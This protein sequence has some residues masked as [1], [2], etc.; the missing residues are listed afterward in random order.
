M[1]LTLK[2]L[3]TICGDRNFQSRKTALCFLLNNIA[4]RH[5]DL[6]AP[7]RL[8]QFLAQ[9]LHE[10]GRLRYVKEI[11]GPTAAQTR[12]EGRRDLG[13][14]L[15]GDGK[16]F[17]GRDIIQIT[18]R[19]NYR[20]LSEWMDRKFGPD[21]VDFEANPDLLESE[22]YLGYGALWYWSTRVPSKF[23]ETGNIEMITRRV[24]GGLN[25][26]NDRLALYDRA[27]L[28]LLG[29]GPEEIRRFQGVAGVGMDGISGPKTRGAMHAALRAIKPT[30]PSVVAPS[31]NPFAALASLLSQ[32][33][34]AL[35]GGKKNG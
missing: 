3:N 13:N 5:T 33:I 9:V 29:Y 1:K 25:G 14:I 7:H 10:S 30:K 21:A 23:V 24:N 20:A 2:Q 28:V 35:F 17:L 15:P 22:E 32:I 6:A 16:R 12:Y 11:W 18:G 26:Y 8:A 27:A 4:P 31:A 19:A 34:A